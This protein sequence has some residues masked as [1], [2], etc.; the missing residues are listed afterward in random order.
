M[1]YS[2]GEKNLQWL[3]QKLS[4]KYGKDNPFQDDKLVE[5]IITVSGMDSLQIF[6]DKYVYGTEPLPIKKVLEWSGYDYNPSLITEEMSW[7]NVSFSVDDDKNLVVSSTEI[8]SFLP[9][10]S[11]FLLSILINSSS[12]NAEISDL[13]SNIFVAYSDMST[14]ISLASRIAI[15]LSNA[16]VVGLLNSNVSEI[17]QDN[18]SPLIAFGIAVNTSSEKIVYITEAVE[19]KGLIQMSIGALVCSPPTSL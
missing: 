5:E 12:E 13:A 10:T 18:I 8:R 16:V 17:I 6:F 7:G 15:S 19:A 4:N 14:S 3:L 11:Y 1:Q 2:G 9:P